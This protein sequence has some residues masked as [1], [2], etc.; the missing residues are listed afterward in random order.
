MKFPCHL[1]K[2]PGPHMGHGGVMYRYIGCRDADEYERL[3]ALG[4][5]AS[6]SDEPV[7]EVIQA[8][9]ATREEMEQKA[10]QLGIRGVHLMKDETLAAKIA[11]RV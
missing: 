8:A 6:L 11:E 5:R 2:T 9:D 3:S 7:K 4:W 10:K 1:Y